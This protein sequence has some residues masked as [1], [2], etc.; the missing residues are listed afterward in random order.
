MSTIVTDRIEKSI[1]EITD[2]IQELQTFCK[3]S[4]STATVLL[5]S[6]VSTSLNQIKDI[7]E[8]AVTHGKE[9]SECLADHEET[10]KETPVNTINEMVDCVNEKLSNAS[11]VV[12]KATEQIT[13]QTKV[14]YNLENKLS[15]CDTGIIGTD[16]YMSVLTEATKQEASLPGKIISLELAATSNLD[17]LKQEAAQCTIVKAYEVQNNITQL[18]EQIAECI[19]QL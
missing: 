17:T 16:C 8:S 10:I 18:T 3:T 14:I 13:G 5:E 1:T 11:S 12:E 9:P 7:K 4:V 15:S 2:T 19:E 6:S